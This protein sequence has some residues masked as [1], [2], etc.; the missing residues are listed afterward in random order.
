MLEMFRAR[1]HDALELWDRAPQPCPFWCWLRVKA[2]ISVA[3]GWEEHRL[4]WA[5]DVI[6]VWASPQSS[7]WTPE[8]AECNWQ[9]VA[10]KPGLSDWRHWRYTNG[11]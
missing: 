3:L 9:E 1:V 8:G 6:P 10:V 4:V 2:S 5:D 11:F 7:R